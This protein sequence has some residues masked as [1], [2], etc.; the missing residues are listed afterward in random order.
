MWRRGDTRFSTPRITVRNKFYSPNNR[1]KVAGKAANYPSPSGEVAV[2]AEGR[3]VQM[4]V[5][6]ERF[7]QPP[8]DVLRK[9]QPRHAELRILR[10]VSVSETRSTAELSE[11]Q[12]VITNV[13]N[14]CG[15]WSNNPRQ[16]QH[17][18]L[19]RPAENLDYITL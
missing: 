2:V 3:G 13:V 8:C 15:A 14:D 1:P 7:I 16:F 11:R 12:F 10:R 5:R 17:L 4:R 18:P 6:V 19:S 9:K